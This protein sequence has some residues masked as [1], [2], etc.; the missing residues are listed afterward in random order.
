MS[1]FLSVLFMLE[2][3]QLMACLSFMRAPKMLPL[4]VS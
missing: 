2:A 3:P 1:E 4:Q